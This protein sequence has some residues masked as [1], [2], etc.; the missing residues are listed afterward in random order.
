MHQDLDLL[1]RGGSLMKSNERLPLMYHDGDTWRNYSIYN[2][3]NHNVGIFV[4]CGPSFNEVDLNVLKGGGKTVLSINTT[5]PTLKPDIWMG[6][7]NPTCYDEKVY[8]EAFP[9]ILRGGFQDH[10]MQGKTLKEYPNTYFASIEEIPLVEK[11]RIFDFSLPESEVFVWHKNSFAV[12]MNVMLYMGFKKIY[13]LGV[14]LSM[15]K[16]NYFDGRD[17][18]KKEIDWNMNL[19]NS[20]YG[21]IE[22]F[23]EECKKIG[24]SVYSLSK[25]SRINDII[26]YVSLEELNESLVLPETTKLVHSSKHGFDLISDEY[27]KILQYEHETTVWGINA[28]WSAEKLHE[29]LMSNSAT[30]VLDYGCGQSSF[31]KNIPVKGYYNVFEYDPGILGKDMTPEPRDYTI[32]ID[33]LEHVEPK[34][35]YNVLEDLRRVTRKGGYFTIAMYPA[36]RILKDGRNAH[37]IVE[38]SFWWINKLREHFIIVKSEQEGLQLNVQV[39]S[40]I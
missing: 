39:E 19:Y 37:L 1:Y 15:E 7:D 6:M 10:E 35:L 22:W 27:K 9:K 20:L 21:Y 8:T 24:V 36:R 30:E 17:L 28:G 11:H 29:W 40:K 38:D 33:V 4:G 2:K 26:K 3:N 16:L 12:A 23:S 32:C 5:Y 31:L 18:N 13:L 25:D 14:D 34:L